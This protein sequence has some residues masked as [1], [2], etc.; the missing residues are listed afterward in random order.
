MRLEKEESRHRIW[1][2]KIGIHTGPVTAS[3]SGKKKVNYDIKGDTVNTASRVEAV[4]DNGSILISV[5]T[6]E[7]VKEFFDCE[8]F[9]KLPV[10]YKGD[11]QMYKVSGLKAEFSVNGAGVIPNESF[12]IKFGLIQFT[13]IQEIIL[14]KLEKELPGLPLLS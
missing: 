9:G 1:E 2:L 10:K 12:R 5:M 14:D 3:V 11:L 6:Y 4:S 7:L 13:D 8:Y